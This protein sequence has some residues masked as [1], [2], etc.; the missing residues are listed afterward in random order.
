MASKCEFAADQLDER[1][2]DQFVAWST[3]DRIRERLLQEPPN[4]KLD[5]L[6]SMAVTIERAMSEVPALSSANHQS[7]ASVGHVSTRRD[8]ASSP[9]SGS[10]CYGNCGKDGH[11]SRSTEC[12]ARGQT[13]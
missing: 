1:V 9:S 11:A 12:P 7:S 3:S 6:L 10:S 13:C 4:R 5:E 2:R 8:L